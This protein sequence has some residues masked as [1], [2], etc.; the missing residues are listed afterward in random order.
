MPPV[1]GEEVA[2]LIMIQPFAESFKLPG[3]LSVKDVQ[4]SHVQ[5]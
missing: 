1:P 3:L 2:T 4:D 5:T